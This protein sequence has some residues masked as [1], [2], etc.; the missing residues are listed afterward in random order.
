MHYERSTIFLVRYSPLIRSQ[1]FIVL[2]LAVVL[3]ARLGELY[4]LEVKGTVIKSE[5][6]KRM[7]NYIKLQATNIRIIIIL[8]IE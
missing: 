4:G 7:P 2:Y 6:D 8:D 3:G 5:V 1:Q